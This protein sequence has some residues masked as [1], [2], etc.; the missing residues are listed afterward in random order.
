MPYRLLEPVA[1][2]SAD[3]PA[4]GN[5]LWG[6]RLGATC[7]PR[8]LAELPLFA[9]PKVIYGESCRLSAETLAAARVTFK[10]IPY[11]LKAR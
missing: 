4:A 6:S 11:D 5:T 8:V 9:G 7:S 3:D 10:Q 1:G 2:L